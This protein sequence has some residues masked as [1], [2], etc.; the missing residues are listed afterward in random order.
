[1]I[2]RDFLHN[3]ALSIHKIYNT[4]S[5]LLFWLGDL[6]LN[7]V[8]PIIVLRH[9]FVLVLEFGEHLFHE[10]I[11]DILFVCLVLCLPLSTSPCSPSP[12]HS[13]VI[14]VHCLP[15]VLSLFV[16]VDY[17]SRQVISLKEL[18]GAAAS[19]W[20]TWTFLLWTSLILIVWLGLPCIH[21]RSP[22]ISC[23][24]LPVLRHLMNGVV[25]LN[26][27]DLSG[28]VHTGL[29]MSIDLTWSA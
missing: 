26:V 5:L 24:W 23:D 20:W 8:I 29:L 18:K 15:L 4:R 19:P 6:Y 11:R 17:F 3:T 27:H 10:K 9:W 14:R 1:M 2:S 25:Q 28:P 13:V 7:T 22:L 12:Y 21:F 16:Y